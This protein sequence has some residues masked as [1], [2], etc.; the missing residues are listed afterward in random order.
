[1]FGSQVSQNNERKSNV[2]REMNTNT[3]AG[4]GPS[5][6]LL[7]PAFLFGGDGAN[8][9]QPRPTPSYPA[10]C[11]ELPNWDDL[12]SSSIGFDVKHVTNRLGLLPS[13]DSA[14]E[15]SRR[16]ESGLPSIRLSSKTGYKQVRAPTLSVNGAIKLPGMA[17]DCASIGQIIFLNMLQTG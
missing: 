9:L 14:M 11:L 8:C 1:V 13:P 6:P 12:V 16:D 10:S 2:R 5:T 7:V 15:L 4:E 3:R 17:K